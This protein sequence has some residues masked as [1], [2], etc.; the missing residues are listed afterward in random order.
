[1]SK[2]RGEGHQYGCYRHQKEED[3]VKMLMPNKF[4]VLGEMDK[5]LEK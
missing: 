1:M 4:E 2:K 5:S 3:M